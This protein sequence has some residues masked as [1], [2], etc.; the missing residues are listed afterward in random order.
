[1]PNAQQG[2]QRQ[3]NFPPHVL[4]VTPQEMNHVRMQRPNLANIPDDQFRGMVLQMKKSSWVQQQMKNQNQAAQ[5]QSRQQ[6]QNQQ[7]PQGQA[8]V[9]QTQMQLQQPMQPTQTPQPQPQQVPNAVNHN[10]AMQG[11]GQKQPSATPEPT[12]NNRQQATNNRPQPPKPSPAPATKNLKRPSNDESADVVELGESAT[13]QSRPAAQANQP[14]QANQ[15]PPHGPKLPQ[16]TPQQIA[17]FSPEQR[18]KYEAYMKMQMAKNAVNVP[19]NPAQESLTRLRIIGQEEQKNFSP[20][21]LVEIPMNPQELSDTAAKLQRIVVDMS[22]IGR[23][24]SKWY[25]ITRDDARAKMFF[26]T[27]SMLIFRR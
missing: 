16:F 8:N 15:Q 4:T 12:R 24:L 19:M 25:S 17:Q 27:V 13:S 11:A 7:G 21:S 23:G 1:M 14:N 26:K 2:M 22:K 18:A 6:A 5:Q 20:Q 10:V 3:I 9:P